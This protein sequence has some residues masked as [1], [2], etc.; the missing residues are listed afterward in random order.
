MLETK[1]KSDWTSL[2]M[3]KM[4]DVEYSE[5][6]ILTLAISIDIGFTVQFFYEIFTQLMLPLLLLSCLHFHFGDNSR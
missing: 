4:F 5:L 1:K 3:M 6:R 2:H